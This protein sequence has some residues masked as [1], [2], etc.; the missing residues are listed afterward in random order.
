MRF[1]FLLIAAALCCADSVSAAPLEDQKLEAHAQGIFG[2]VLSPFCPGRALNDCPSSQAHALK[3]EIRQKVVNGIP[4]ETIL[5]GIIS[6]YGEQYRA[7]PKPEGFGLMIWLAP[8]AFFAI[9]ASAVFVY[10][11]R[12]QAVSE[13]VVEKSG[14]TALSP[15]DE[16]RI[17]RALE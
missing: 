1:K 14:K 3:D 6:E 17:S 11:R 5:S 2:Q 15:E 10:S 8:I 4:D 12:R 16:E 13:R 9:G 7:L